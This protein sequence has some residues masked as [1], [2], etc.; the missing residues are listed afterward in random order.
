[1]KKHLFIV[2][3]I[4]CL[5]ANSTIAKSE[6][7]SP[8]PT[9]TS[10]EPKSHPKGQK[11][12][13]SNQQ[14]ITDRSISS[15]NSAITQQTKPPANDKSDKK[16][17]NATT[18]WWIVVFTAVLALAAV[19][20][21]FTALFQL[22]RLRQTVEVTKEAADAAKKSADAT[23]RTVLAMQ[24]TAQR[25]LRAYVCVPGATI[26]ML[27]KTDGTYAHV[28]LRY[29]NAGQT[30][31]HDVRTWIAL[32]IAEYPLNK[33]LVQ[34]PHDAKYSPFIISPGSEQFLPNEIRITPE[35][36]PVFGTIKATLYVYG[37]IL[38]R[39][40]FGIERLTNYRLL[41]GGDEGTF[42]TRLR[43][44]LEGNEADYSQT[45]E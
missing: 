18:N 7:P 22:R 13:T 23:E 36:L 33:V 11:N 30:P 43:P 9:K 10:N 37:E 16:D 19:A 2:F 12:T 25:Q 27:K 8:T 6:P 21:F 41:Y 32:H 26:K 42:G 5:F 20:Q 1:M 17:S 38:Y 3:A 14:Q 31:G 4:L 34:P 44:D 35:Q 40:V 39:D 28:V 29:K 45:H 24:A 15:D